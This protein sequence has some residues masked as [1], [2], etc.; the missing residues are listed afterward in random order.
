MFKSI[1]LSAVLI[2]GLFLSDST[3]AGTPTCQ[4][5][6]NGS[7]YCSYNGKVKQIYINSGG[8]ILIYFDTPLSIDNAA[9][10]GYTIT[11]GGVSAFSFAENPDF[12]KLFYSTAL[13]AQAS[14]RSI[15]MQMRGTISNYMKFDRIWLAE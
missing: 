8:L 7:P 14:G 3:V 4:L 1:I 6:S 12:A 9:S 11:N 2:L 10:V 5:A 13:A 15:S